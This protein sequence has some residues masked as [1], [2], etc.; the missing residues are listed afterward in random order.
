MNKNVTT[1]KE[2]DKVLCIKNKYDKVLCIKNRYTLEKWNETKPILFEKNKLY[3]I[4]FHDNKDNSVAIGDN[5]HNTWWYFLDNK[6][7]NEKLDRLFSD[8]FLTPQQLRKQKLLKLNESH[9]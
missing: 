7:G 5:R 9:L 8:Y 6:K 3:T 2:Y 4:L 1:I